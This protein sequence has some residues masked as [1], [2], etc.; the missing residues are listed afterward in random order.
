MK[1]HETNLTGS[2]QIKIL[3]CAAAFLI[4]LIGLRASFWE[5]PSADHALLADEDRY[6]HRR[7][8]LFFRDDVKGESQYGLVEPESIADKAVV[9]STADLDCAFEVNQT[10]RLDE[11][12]MRLRRESPLRFERCRRVEAIG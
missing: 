11:I 2:G 1:P 6:G 9:T 4:N 12:K 3:P 10:E 7:E 5:K 8:T